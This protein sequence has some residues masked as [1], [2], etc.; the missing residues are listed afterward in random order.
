[1]PAYNLTQTAFTAGEVSPRVRGRTDLDRYGYALKACRNAH[2]VV[3]GGL[4]RRPG[5]IYAAVATLAAALS[6]TLIPFA[7]GIGKC[8]MLEPGNNTVRIYNADRTYTGI[9]L[10]SPYTSAQLPL[11]DWVQ[12]DA[13]MYVFHPDV[14]THRLQ[15]LGANTWVLSPA[16]FT[17]MPFD[18]IGFVAFLASDVGRGVI[19]DAGL[20]VITGYTST[21]VATVEITRVFASVNLPANGWTVDVSPQADLTPGAKDPVGA[22]TTLTLSAAGWRTTDVGSV[23]RVNGGLLRITAYTSPTVVDAR[24]L[25]ELSAVVAAPALAWSLEPPV[26]SAVLGYPRTGTV[27]QQRLIVAGNRKFPRTVWG[28]RTGEPLDFERWTDDGDSFA[29]TIDSDDATAITYIAAGA[30][31]AIFTE[32]GEYSMRGGVEKPITPTNVRVKQETNHGCAQVRPAQINDEQYF[33]QRA[34]RKVRAFTYRYDKGEAGG[35]TA[36]DI[37]ALAQHVTIGNVTSMAYS[38]E[39]EQLL[40]ASLGSGRFLSCTIDRDQ[41]PSVIAWAVHMTDGFVE[42][43]ASLP[44]D[45]RDQI[46]MIVRRVINGATVRYIEVLDDTFEPWHPSVPTPPPP[47]DDDTLD[48]NRPVYGT[49]VDCA[50]VIDNAGGQDTFA[51][52]HLIGKTVDIVADGAKQPQQLVPL[53]GNIT[54]QRT[55]K[56]T[57]IG[58]P[59][60]S[61]ATLLTPEIQTQTGSAQGKP[62]RTGK[63]SLHVL[64]SIG[65]KVQNNSGLIEQ[66]PA[67]KFGANVLD[68]P[69]MPFTGIVD[70][71]KLGWEKAKSEISII[72]DDPMPFHVL[73]VVRNHSVEG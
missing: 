47:D 39:A 61:R 3:Q 33:V 43:V 2:T 24:I 58:L 41:Q 63:V 13:T 37:T 16:P 66:L 20:A 38:Q 17:T 11:L 54:L 73:A 14:P 12:S 23:V 46:W 68:Q 59:F 26:W 18:E 57:L 1:M 70:V 52:P 60:R 21:T 9:Q 8:W 67:R 72:Q 64:D 36:P 32:T 65:A 15:R 49:T 25:R 5:S 7:E 55:S 10:V 56:R 4:K 31:L 62:V 71:T 30:G 69:P 19:S 28:S 53:S 27:Y 45:D 34:G 44:T 6:T 50:I 51:V 29:F 42:C 48:S 40:W 35:Y 22:T